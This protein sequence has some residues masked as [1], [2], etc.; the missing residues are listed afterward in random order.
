LQAQR[1]DCLARKSEASAVALQRAEQRSID[2]L[3]DWNEE[4][5]YTAQAKMKLKAAN[6]AFSQYRGTQCA[7]MSSLRGGA[8]GGALAMCR[9]TCIIELNTHRANELAHS[10]GDLPKR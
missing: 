1:R 8:V 9:F 4:A 5:E 10:V 2:A 7:F 3:S 6:R